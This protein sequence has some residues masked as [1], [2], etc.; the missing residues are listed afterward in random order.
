M[1][2]LNFN[3][4]ADLQAAPP[5]E[6]AALWLEAKDA[7][8]AMNAYRIAVEEAL[9]KHL[10]KKEEGS[11]TH[12]IGGYKVTITGTM[13]RKL[14]AEK[15]REIEE[16]VPVDRRPVQ[17]VE[18]LDEKGCK[19]L[20]ENDPATWSLVAQAVTVKPGKTGVKVVAHGD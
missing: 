20:A 10:G 16:Q 4:K 6:L 17:L 12:T 1:T 9:E 11:Q 15:W 19:W 18:K 13:S 2:L 5:E 7:E 8:A 14:D 3:N